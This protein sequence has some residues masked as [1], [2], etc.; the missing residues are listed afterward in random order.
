M[1]Y[2]LM[3]KN[4]PLLRFE[5]YQDDFG[6]TEV[7]ELEWLSSV[8][9]I[10]YQGLY[11]F[12][13]HRKAPKHRKH[14]EQLL[15][16][17]GCDE[18]EGF[19][20]VSHAL[21]LNDTFWVKEEESPMSWSE[22][23]LYQNEFNEL[24]AQAA[25][26]GILSDTDISSTSPE[27]GTDGYYAKCWVRDKDGIYLC[28]SGSNTFELEP[29]SEYLASQLA[30]AICPDHVAYD[31]AV[32][33]D[34]VVSKCQLFTSEKIGLAKAAHVT[35]ER[36]IAGLLRYFESISAGEEF[37]RMCI[38]DALILNID[39]HTGNFGVLFGTDTTSITGMAPV[40]DN[41]R[42]LCFDLDNDQLRNTDWILRKCRPAIGA[43]FI[44]TARGMLTDS[45]R[46]DL[47]NLA[48]FRFTQH[49]SIAVDSE[50]LDLLSG[51]VNLQ[52]KRILE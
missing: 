13:D 22:V 31:L 38:L 4:T 46:R 26:D 9:P 16:R 51:L 23:S 7:R 20:R 14:I 24:I 36:S 19:L 28:K 34:K 3:N 39:R 49:D 47:K 25:F 42:S 48:G 21:S 43:D 8:R 50:R 2:L 35:Q 15:N 17:Y 40:Y 27:F 1:N 33:H 41:N 44:A 11:S 45:I 18:L 30:A 29:L 52:I 12:L 6:E 5:C 10:G 37:R 32:L